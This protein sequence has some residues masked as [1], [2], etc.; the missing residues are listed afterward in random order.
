MPDE[1]YKTDPK[2]IGRHQETTGIMVR[3]R[4]PQG[5]DSFDIAELTRDSLIAWL[6]IEGD[7]NP[8]A[9]SVVLILLGHAPI[10]PEAAFAHK[11]E[12]T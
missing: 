5:W 12:D 6:R 4:G 10:V 2:R 11:K 7:K 8:W 1:I 9:E 3:A